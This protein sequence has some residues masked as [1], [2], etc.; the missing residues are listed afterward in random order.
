M[1]IHVDDVEEHLQVLLKQE[2]AVDYRVDDYLGDG[3][4]TIPE[5]FWVGRSLTTGI[6]HAH[7]G[8]NTAAGTGLVLFVAHP[9]SLTSQGRWQIGQWFYR[10]KSGDFHMP[11]FVP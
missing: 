7:F 10:S 1:G 3:S 2:N 5:C 4:R 6:G 9:W 8:T 11:A